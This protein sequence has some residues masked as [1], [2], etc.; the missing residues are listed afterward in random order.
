MKL[1]DSHHL[2]SAKIS[3]Q[4][5]PSRITTRDYSQVEVDLQELLRAH[6]MLVDT[7]ISIEKRLRALVLS[8]QEQ[9]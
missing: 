4:W 1:T 6:I 5:D 7:S 8:V 9:V 2:E 3:Q